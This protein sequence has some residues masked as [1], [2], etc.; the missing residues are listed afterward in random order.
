MAGY[1]DI[2]GA[3][4]V[5]MSCRFPGAPNLE[6][7]WENLA[8]GVCSLTEFTDAEVAQGLADVYLDPALR[9]QPAFIKAGYVLQDVDM[10]DAEFFGFTAREA[11][12]ADPQE[13][14]F[15][16]LVWEALE[17]A[18]YSPDADLR[19]GVYAGTGIS[20]Y[21]LVNLYAGMELG[22]LAAL[23]YLFG[24]DKDYLTTQ[25]SFRL[26]L[27]G[28]S[29][30]V[31]SACSTGL[32][33]LMLACDALHD[34]Q[35]DLAI[36]GGVQ[37][38]FPQRTGYLHVEGSLL[39]RDGRCR[40]FDAAATGTNFGSGAGVVV[41]K[42]LEDA[43]RDRDTIWAV[44]RDAAVNNDGARKVGFTAPSVDGQAEV[45]A[46]AQARAE[47]PPESISYIEAHGTGTPLGDPIEIAALNRVFRASTQKKGF[48][49]IGSVKTNVGHLETAAGAAGL[50]KAALA[51]RHRQIPPS[52]HFERA[53]PQ[54]DFANSP[55]YVNTALTEWRRLE[56]Y[57]RRAGVSSFG[58]GG[59]NAHAILEEAPELPPAGNA[60]PAPYLLPLS[61][62]SEPAL[63][64]LAGSYARWLTSHQDAALADVCYT[65]ALGRAHWE[66]R[67]AVVAESCAEMEAQLTAL[68]GAPVTGAVN[69]L[70][71]AVASTAARTAHV[72]ERNRSAGKLQTS[73]W[74]SHVQ[75]L[76]RTYAQGAAIDWRAVYAPWTQR[77]IPLPT[78]PF[79]RK[80]YWV[81]PAVVGRRAAAPSHPLL[82]S[83]VHVA[84][85]AKIRFQTV[86]DAD[87]PA[88]LADHRLED[89]IVVP[90]AAFLSAIWTAVAE[91]S[92]ERRVALR[93]VTILAPLVLTSDQTML[94]TTLEDAGFRIH[95]RAE[96]AAPGWTLH[97]QGRIEDAADSPQ[98]PIDIQRLCSSLDDGLTPARLYRAFDENG[99]HYGAAFRGIIGL[100]RRDGEALAQLALPDALDCEE[101]GGVPHAALVDAAFQATGAALPAALAGGAA[102]YVPMAADR[103]AWFGPAGRNIWSHVRVRESGGRETVTADLNFHNG[104]GALLGCAEGLRFRRACQPGEPAEWLYEIRWRPSDLPASPAAAHGSFCF[105]GGSA[106]F[107]ERVAGLVRERGGNAAVVDANF[108][109]LLTGTDA[110]DHIVYLAA[111]SDAAGLEEIR[112][113]QRQGSGGLVRLIAG[114]VRRPHS[115]S[116][117]LW[118]VTRGAQPV[119]GGAPLLLAQTPLWGLAKAIAVEHPELNISCIDLPPE[120]QEGQERQLL[121]ELLA[122][123]GERQVGYRQGRRFVARLVHSTRAAVRAAGPF[124]LSLSKYGTPENVELVPA[125]RRQP[126]PGEVEIEV[127]AAGLNFKD[128]MFVLGL[129][130][131]HAAEMG[132]ASAQDLAL[133]GEC[134]GVVRTVGP[135]VEGFAPGDAVIAALAPGAASSVVTLDSRF[136]IPKPKAL[137]MEEA[138]GVSI[139][140]LT[141]RYALENLAGLQPGERILIHA[142]AG[143]VGQAA[144]QLAQRTGT[145][146]FATASPSKWPFLE[147]IGVKHIFHS[148]TMD[149]AGQIRR[150]T[151]GRG[152]DVVLNSLNGEFIPAGLEALAPGGRFIELGRAGTWSAAQVAAIRPDAR[153]FWFDLGEVALR[154]PGTV[155]RLVAELGRELS[156]GTLPPLPVTLFP[157]E[158]AERALRFMAQAK[159]IGKIVFTLPRGGELPAIVADGTYWIT[160]GLGALGLRVAR[161]LVS[162]GARH[163]ALTGRHPKQAQTAVALEELRRDG[164]RVLV[165]PADVSRE[166]DVLSALRA[167]DASLPPLQGIFHAAG[168]LDDGLLALQ[169]WDRFERV[170]APKVYG[171]W[172][173]HALT[174][175]RQLDYFVCFS[176]ITSLLGVMGQ[177][178]YAAAN[179]FL[180]AL[181]HH[182]RAEGLP[183]VTIDW[184]EWAETGMAARADRRIQEQWERMGIRAIPPEKGLQLLD[185]PALH[186]AAQVA[187]FPVDWRR[188]LAQLPAEAVRFFEE[189]HVQR[190]EPAPVGEPRT[191]QDLEAF[192]RREIALVLG[193]NA[194]RHIRAQESLFSLG[195]DSLTAVE[196][197]SRLEAGLGRE[198]PATLLFDYPAL[199]TLL[200]R[201]AGM[202]HPALSAAR[203]PREVGQALSSTSFDD[204]LSETER[205]SDADLL[206]RIVNR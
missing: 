116:P 57:P 118:L 55:F 140:W 128:L 66:W 114:L 5:G 134:A 182:R 63:R 113:A 2:A 132:I 79:Q 6:K 24:N 109:R 20:K 137:T 175:S 155:W 170:L 135:G 103:L 117:R 28:P 194:G 110:H 59:T 45:I 99:L 34:Y 124:R 152:V 35:C 30:C 32:T 43:L 80:R 16:E 164:A 183:A 186:D 13:R 17:T 39:S 206:Q 120:F 61:A 38:N 104:A 107:A 156:A 126:G 81:S 187:V 15:L 83:R 105:V 166:D 98:L 192:V 196:L 93:D 100:W 154:E 8:A 165:I 130:K 149:F 91:T 85:D 75:D 22:N 56:G 7:F 167:I 198:L 90:A 178:S 201:L 153:Y 26:N 89:Q 18:G 127:H 74:R 162:K 184:S 41:L 111:A 169:T 179:S 31:Q 203:P 96:R 92:P 52:L 58:I 121:A 72:A 185:S 119:L 146:V 160:G 84:E 159:H 51:L 76:A 158:E 77:R 3:A 62:K 138:A 181:A 136:V 21:L 112:E 129:L 151:G 143:G 9:H 171:A 147:S 19:I 204:V 33:A 106:G 180:D 4:I 123:D 49:A 1:I 189:I 42:R 94:Q 150:L 172:N 86:L 48:C 177:G 188:F 200:P 12:L 163:L 193:L 29:V 205:L 148:R 190:P 64:A 102:L 68:A 40:V 176:S 11:Q 60:A 54:I 82:G 65:A 27:R 36:A 142:A 157:I 71:E 95:S 199:E 139:A 87:S 44:V 133:G 195:L 14:I 174:R 69:R 25:S 101:A 197:K 168:R 78:Y 23:Q 70:P 88:F 67:H 141:A 37:V 53:N 125:S 97:C 202:Q 161:W 47:T 46:A 131:H 173:L 73:E 145:E 144:V 10:F 122:G 108:G 191:H 115:R 50:I